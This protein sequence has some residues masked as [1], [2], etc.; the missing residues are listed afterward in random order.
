MHSAVHPPLWYHIEEFLPSKTP[1]G[2]QL[3]ILPVVD[4][5]TS[6]HVE[7][8]YEFL[9]Q[10]DTI[11]WGARSQMLCSF[12]YAFEIKERTK[13]DYMEAGESKAEIRLQDR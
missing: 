1:L 9:N 2:L 5:K 13:E 7:D 3:F 8:F 10:P 6:K 11:C 4:I 12:F